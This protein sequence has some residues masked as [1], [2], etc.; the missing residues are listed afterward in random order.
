VTPLD[1]TDVVFADLDGVIYTGD[2]A[3]PFAVESLNAA[4]KL[5]RLAYITNNASRT[6]TAIAEHLNKLGLTVTADD[7]VSS[8]QAAVKIL[9]TLVDPGSTILVIG[10]EGLISEVVNAGFVV[11]DSADDDPA[12]VI[13]GFAP[14]VG[15]VHL[16]EASF[17]LHRGIPWV[18]TNT[19]WTIPV[20]RGVAPGNGTLVSAVHLAVGRLPVFAGK[21]E[22][23]IFDYA[24]GRFE[25][26]NAL[27][28]GDRLDTDILGANRAGMRSALVLTGIDG[29]KQ[30]LASSEDHQPTYILSDLRELSQPYPEAVV[31]EKN[32]VTTVTVRKSVVTMSGNVVRM[33][34]SGSSSIDLLRAGATAIYR[35]GLRIY[36]LDVDPA[37]YS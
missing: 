9:A 26:S 30:V 12:A 6:P 36:G 5:V 20:A 29:P 3:V 18:A 37:I 16:A 32:G 33:K 24:A 31:V 34:K 23:A 25:A 19:D 15:W 13:Q 11:T 35:S 2:N 28:I 1:G 4:A 27:V 22:K 10:G 21:P 8:P 17:A 7:I 14:T